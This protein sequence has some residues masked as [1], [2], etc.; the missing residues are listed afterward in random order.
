MSV[1]HLYSTGNHF[2]HDAD[3]SRAGTYFYRYR[4]DYALEGAQKEKENELQENEGET[5]KKEDDNKK[6]ESIYVIFEPFEITFKRE[7]VKE[8]KGIF[9]T[10]LQDLLVIPLNTQH[11][12]FLEL[13][14]QLIRL[15][16]QDDKDAR[17]KK[18]DGKSTFATL[19]NHFIEDLYVNK[20]FKEFGNTQEIKSALEHVPVLQGIVYKCLFDYYAQTYDKLKR[21]DLRIG[22]AYEHFEDAYLNYSK[23]LTHPQNEKLFIKGAWFVSLKNSHTENIDEELFRVEAQYL[24]IQ[25]KSE[26][27]DSLF[28]YPIN[29]KKI[30]KRY[31]IDDILKLAISKEASNIFIILLSSVIFFIL[32]DALIFNIDIDRSQDHIRLKNF[33]DYGMITCGILFVVFTF[34][35][36]IYLV[37][38]YKMRIIPAIFLPRMVVAIISGWLIFMSAEELLKID[39]DIGSWLLFIVGMVI[40]L[41]TITF[42]VF[43]VNNYAPAMIFPTVL[44][45]ALVVTGLA[46]LVSYSFGFWVMS[47][48]GQK[49]ISIDSFVVDESDFTKEFSKQVIH[50]QTNLDFCISKQNEI[51]ENIENINNKSKLNIRKVDSIKLDNSY[52]NTTLSEIDDFNKIKKEINLF[53]EDLNL[54]ISNYATL[55]QEIDKN[56]KKD[57]LIKTEFLTLN[58]HKDEN[59]FK[60]LFSEKWDKN[61]VNSIENHIDNLKS[62]NDYFIKYIAN[63]P[64]FRVN[65]KNIST[66]KHNIPFIKEDFITFPNML[67]TRALLAMFIGVFLQLI[68]QDKSITEPL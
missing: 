36:G 7:S 23:F 57:T 28:Q 47:Y 68:I 39:I 48:V 22:F 21:K 6:K 59:T 64:E 45:R 17:H 29:L 2:G 43:E 26:K 58:F 11:N 49:F 53:K 60:V 14:S 9:I 27:Q 35:V 62:T 50:F 32:A 40:L 55:L 66:K 1:E 52:S 24:D 18:R 4:H 20:Y 41:L 31:G 16:R 67:L 54:L 37:C 3:R 15:K 10:E 13:E 33:I 51:Y 61:K 42:M 44:R 19:L 65:E 30:I 34:F 38:K 5:Q 56:P 8:E 63:N 12:S 46:F 25:Q